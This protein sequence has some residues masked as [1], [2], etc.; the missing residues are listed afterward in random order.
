MLSFFFCL[1]EIFEE[2]FLI[3]FVF[4]EVILKSLYMGIFMFECV[5]SKWLVVKILLFLLL[6]YIF[7]GFRIIL[8]RLGRSFLFNIWYLEFF[9]K[10]YNLI[11]EGRL[12]IFLF[13]IILMLFKM[14]MI[15]FCFILLW[16]LIYLRKCW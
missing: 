11:I 16:V 10:L 7:L 14:L 1:K 8:W 3:N 13:L 12:F 6:K 4:F 9:I 15:I 2:N 5:K